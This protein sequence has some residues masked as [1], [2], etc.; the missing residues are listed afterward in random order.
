MTNR[1]PITAEEIPSD[2]VID[3][4]EPFRSRMGRGNWRALGNHFGLTQFGVSFETLQ[5]YAQSSVRHWHTLSDEFVYMI[6][7]E[8]TLI[9]DDGEFIL[10]PGM[11]MGFKAGE[12]N[13]HHLINK[14][15]AVAKFMVVGSRAPRDLAFYPDDDL[16]W[17]DTEHGRIAVHKDG[18]PYP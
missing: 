10:S 2:S 1:I 15:H 7:G 6:E 8:L 3:Y 11:C 17:S 18:S 5:P 14:S 13:A 12:K 4:P 9:T 16:A